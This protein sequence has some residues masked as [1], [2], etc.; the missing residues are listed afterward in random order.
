[1]GD[2]VPLFPGNRGCGK[3]EKPAAV[4]TKGSMLVIDGT[5]GPDGS[6]DGIHVAQK[7]VTIRIDGLELKPKNRSRFT[8]KGGAMAEAAAT[9]KARNRVKLEI[10]AAVGLRHAPPSR[11]V[12]TRLSFGT[13]DRG[14]VWEACKPV[15][16]GIAD[17]FELKSDRE[18]QEQGD[19]AQGKCARGTKGVI[20]ELFF[21]V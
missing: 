11:V 12:V 16:D 1:M 7:Q 2:Q 21:S 20:I 19:V 18:L 9:R 15:W 6:F 14:A 3:R 5:L 4:I 13:L 8:T 17:A 10:V